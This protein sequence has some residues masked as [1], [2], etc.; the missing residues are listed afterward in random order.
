MS[1][2]D[3]RSNTRWTPEAEIVVVG[4]D[5]ELAAYDRLPRVLRDVMKVLPAPYD[6]TQILAWALQYDAD[7]VADVI[8]IEA[9]LEHQQFML[10][11]FGY[12]PEVQRR[13]Y[14]P[15]G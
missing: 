2:G 8:K 12:P 13:V 1:R 5:A 3:R 10:S 9:H 11:E 4:R 15:R 7:A 14:H 6:A